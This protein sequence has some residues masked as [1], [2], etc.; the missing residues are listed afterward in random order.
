MDSFSCL[1]DFEL[2]AI[3]ASIG[4]YTRPTLMI[5]AIVFSSIVILLR[6][7]WVFPGAGVA[8]L[9]RTRIA[10]RMKRL[11]VSARSSL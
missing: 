3:R 1:S 11:R 7:V 2:P 9:M 5:D 6:I 10:P 8:W 4:E